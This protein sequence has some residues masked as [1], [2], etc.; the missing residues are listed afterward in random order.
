MNEVKTTLQRMAVYYLLLAVHFALS[1]GVIVHNFPTRN[2]TT[3]YL[4]TLAVCL[5]LYYAH[6]VSPAGK[7]AAMMRALS[8]MELLLILLRGVKYSAF[9]GVGVL[10]RHTWYLYYLPLLFLPLFLYYIAL[11]VS[12]NGTERRPKAWYLPLAVTA[13]LLVMVLTND[14][15]Q[16]VFVFRP[17]FDG[18]DGDYT[19]GWLF[20]VQLAW[21]I[22]LSIAA[23]VILVHRCRVGSAK[24]HAWLLLIPVGVGLVLSAMLLADKLLHT[25]RMTL[26]EMPEAYIFTA[27]VM[28]ECCMQL[29]LVPTN[30]DYGKLFRN[31]SIAAQITDK[32]GNP[33]YASAT[34]TP[35]TAAQIDLPDGARI[36]DHTVLHKMTIAGG[37]GFWQDDMTALDQLNEELAEAKEGLA[38]E[39]ELIRLRNELKEKQAKIERRTKL[40]DAIAR[41]TQRQSQAISHL[42]ERAR[43]SDDPALR[44][45]CRR[46]ITLL[47]AYIKRFANLMLLSEVSET[48]EAGEM[49]LSFAELLRYLNYCGIPGECI[50]HADGTVRASA[51]L[52]VFEAAETLIETNLDC[53][54]GVFV[55][56]SGANAATCKMACEGLAESLSAAQTTA[57]TQ[58][59]VTVDVRRE[60]SVTYLCFSLPKGGDAA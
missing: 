28:L 51:A 40:Y 5:V 38:E 6:R 8:V 16:Q 35:L 54:A 22:A 36:N 57:L 7:F 21:Q 53:L 47:G 37:Y 11:L 30:T 50:S 49:G 34:A 15:H 9:A 27:A 33:V 39:A 52:A 48:I 13:A 18:W 31:L 1:M 17:D 59:G 14:L 19:Y 43:R 24:K 20:Y 46:R 29:G 41:S 4:L 23:I 55:N 56:L 60:D 10:A 26:L 12:S 42:A 45:I 58:A 32:K 3:L 25:H 44:D 2:L